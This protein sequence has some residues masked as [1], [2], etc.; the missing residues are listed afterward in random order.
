M[1]RPLTGPERG[2][3]GVGCEKQRD[4]ESFRGYEAEIRLSCPD[5]RPNST[6]QRADPL[7]SDSSPDIAF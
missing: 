4:S 1:R 2:G 5:F 7:S 3:P 6:Y